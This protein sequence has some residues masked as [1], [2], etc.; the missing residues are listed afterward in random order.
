MVDL[1]LRMLDDLF[2]N[3]SAQIQASSISNQQS[4]TSLSMQLTVNWP[5]LLLL[6]III[7]AS[8]PVLVM[9]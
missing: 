7:S 1:G 8:W 4:G 3:F 5:V 2:E 6:M 9:I